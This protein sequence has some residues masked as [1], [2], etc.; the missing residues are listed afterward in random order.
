[1]FSAN[2]SRCH[3]I[4]SELRQSLSP[5]PFS[6]PTSVQP[7]R[8]GSGIGIPSARPAIAQL[9]GCS[10][11]ISR[12]SLY[13]GKSGD[14]VRT[15]EVVTQEGTYID[16]LRN[17]DARATLKPEV[18]ERLKNHPSGSVDFNV[19]DE[20]KATALAMSGCGCSSTLTSFTSRFLR[21]QLWGLTTSSEQLTLAVVLFLLAVTGMIACYAPSQRA[22]R[23][24]PAVSL[25]SE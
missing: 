9:S 4:R 17:V 6:S 14:C 8:P 18:Q 3:F 16:A 20:L 5:L 12:C 10:P 23:V 25:K 19:D 2:C 7:P 15:R 13:T 24:S 11:R 21:T 1:M 22:A